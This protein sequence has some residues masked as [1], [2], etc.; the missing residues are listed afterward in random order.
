MTRRLKVYD[1]VKNNP[2]DVK[3]NDL[4]NLLLEK[5]FDLK[6]SSGSHFIFSKDEIVFVIPTHNN[7]V[8]E[9]YVKRVIDIIEKNEGD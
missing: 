1:K 3:F 2:K 4:K 5:G 7:K 9:I 8:K 6:R